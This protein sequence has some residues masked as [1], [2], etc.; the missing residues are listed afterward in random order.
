VLYGQP[1]KKSIQIETRFA[2]IS[3]ENKSAAFKCI[4][5]QQLRCNQIV[6][7]RLP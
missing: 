7:H 6:A 2:Q 5:M 1:E 4:Q 3:V